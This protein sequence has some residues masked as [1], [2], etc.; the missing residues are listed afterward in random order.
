MGVEDLITRVLT[1]GNI[2][3]VIQ[4]DFDMENMKVYIKHVTLTN[5][6][7]KCRLIAVI[8]F[9]KNLFKVFNISPIANVQ[10]IEFIALG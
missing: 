4:Y 1:S 8:K 6:E 5:N 10:E 7:Y 2:S 3:E 9:I